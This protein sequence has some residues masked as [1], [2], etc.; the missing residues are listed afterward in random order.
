MQ[1]CSLRIAETA[2]QFMVAKLQAT[3]SFI[4]DRLLEALKNRIAQ[5]RLPNLICTL[6]YL[7]NSIKY[8]AELP[9]NIFPSPGNDTI[10][11]VIIEI[12]E[13]YFFKRPESHDDEDDIDLLQLQ[14]RQHQQQNETTRDTD[15]PEMSFK[16]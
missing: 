7:H 10:I 5:R 16:E 4:S 6:K 3:N 12:N 15:E 13:R 8:Y 2:L 11:E 1:I 9:S 14:Q